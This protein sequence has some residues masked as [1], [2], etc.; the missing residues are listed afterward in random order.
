MCSGRNVS[1]QLVIAVMIDLPMQNTFSDLQEH[2][3]ETGVLDN[4]VVLL[5]KAVI[6]NYVKISMHHIAK[7]NNQA[8]EGLDSFYL[9]WPGN[10]L[11]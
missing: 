5:I 1:E 2:M 10:P 11:G 6:K 9:L 8:G 7:E 3:T 4:H